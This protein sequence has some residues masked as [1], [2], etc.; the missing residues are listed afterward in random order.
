MM[1]AP[2]LRRQVGLTLI[3][4][5][6]FIVVVS[7][8]LAGILSVLNVTVLHSADPLVQ[9]QA[10]AL[11]EGLL[12]EIQTGY[13]AYCDG[14]DVNMK[15]GTNT[16]GLCA[17]D[18]YRSTQPCAEGRP[19]D[20]VIHYATAADTETALLSALPDE[21]SISAPAGYNAFVTI[22]PQALGDITSASGDALLVRVRVTGPGS[23]QAIAEG[24]KTR[25]APQ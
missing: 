13:F 7:V 25:Q 22:G 11:A 24:F 23:I 20:S 9:K 18:T 21:S 1:A 8:G 6:I 14:A 10:Q 15:Y 5:I 4:L 16:N 19:C 3:E 12:E 17:A 2:S